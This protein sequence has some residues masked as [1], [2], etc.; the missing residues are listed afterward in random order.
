MKCDLIIIDEVN[1]KF[2][3]L[4][5]DIIK[6][7]H[8][9][10][11]YVVPG[12]MFSAKVKLG[13]W[14]GKIS[15]FDS[16]GLTYV[17]FLP[18]IIPILVN[19][20]GVKINV[21]DRRIKGRITIDPIDENFLAHII[22]PDTGKPTILRPY[23][24]TMI[25]KLTHAMSGIGIAGTGAGKTTIT[26]V[27]CQLFNAKGINCL[28][29]VPS[30]T[31]VKQT[32]AGLTACGMPDVG[33]FSGKIKD[34]KNDTIVATWQ[35]LQNIP[36]FVAEFGQVLV[37]EAHG[38]KSKVVKELLTIH[39]RNIKYRFGVTATLPKEDLDR[40]TILSALGEVKDEIPSHV[41]IEQGYL[42]RLDIEVSQ[43]IEDFKEEY[44]EY[45]ASV[46][47]GK[48]VKT[49]TQW[50]NSYFIDYNA[51]KSYIRGKQSRVEYIAQELVNR[52]LCGQGNVFALVD[53][54]AF[55]KK[56]TKAIKNLTDTEHVYFVH[57]QD[58]VEDRQEIYKLFKDHDG[59]IVVATVH[60]AG[61]GL[62]ISR[63][64]N[65]GLIDLGKSFIRTLQT[66]GRGLRKAPDKDYVLVWD[67]CSDLKYSKRHLGDRI[68]YY[69]E[70]KYPYHKNKVEY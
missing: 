43:L 19:E 6:Y 12:A 20:L 44:D 29:I 25:N 56:L 1:C 4:H 46:N 5:G 42:A 28:V 2:N 14:D 8:N 11:N 64:Y 49:Y 24:V 67:V 55:G 41:L 54:V 69:K 51:E 3:N 10:F 22:H 32:I 16:N 66:I 9:E 33:E 63:I 31:L 15:L 34:T 23:Q 35:T 57:G 21:I 39:G 27:I 61:T 68:K 58:K 52:S 30:T 45:V 53:S 50:K 17:H 18:I 65:I 40:M 62:D 70:A 47:A 37:D 26:A 36:Q 38:A 7:L 59:V 48:P 13:M 60:S